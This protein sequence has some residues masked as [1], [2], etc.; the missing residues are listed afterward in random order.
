MINESSLNKLGGHLSHLNIQ[1]FGSDLNLLAPLNRRDT[2]SSSSI[3][4]H[5]S[6]MGLH[7]LATLEYIN[8]FEERQE[9]IQK[10]STNRM[11]TIHAQLS[12]QLAC[13][14]SSSLRSIMNQFTLSSFEKSTV[15]QARCNDLK[16]LE[17]SLSMKKMKLKETQLAFN[18]F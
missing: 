15:E 14:S 13:V 16:A 3:S 17:L 11:L 9:S 2:I 7:P 6:S 12:Q 8:T 18:N 10:D 4:D 1:N 5:H